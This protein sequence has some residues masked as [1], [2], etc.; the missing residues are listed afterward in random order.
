[1]PSRK[2]IHE[3]PVGLFAHRHEKGTRAVS[4]PPPCPVRGLRGGFAHLDCAHVMLHFELTDPLKNHPPNIPS[5]LPV[6]EAQ[7]ARVALAET[8]ASNCLGPSLPSVAFAL[9]SVGC[10]YIGVKV[11]RGCKLGHD[12]LTEKKHVGQ[13][14]TV[15]FVLAD[16]LLTQSIVLSK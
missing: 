5:G 8:A 13:T 9:D 7:L 6:T 10:I 15:Q 1:M 12:K 3:L 2:L 11:V 14:I 4:K 16:H